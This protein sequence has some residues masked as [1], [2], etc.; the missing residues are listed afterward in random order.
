MFKRSV[1]LLA[2]VVAPLGAQTFKPGRLP[3]TSRDSF[4]IV[5]QGQSIG[6]FVMS[7]AKT[8]ENITLVSDA[9]ISVMGGVT[10]LDSLVFNATTLAPV[11]AT[12]A[13]AMGPM[14]ANGRVTIANGKATG[15]VQQPGPNG[16]QTT[17]VDVAIPAGTILDG[18]DALLIPTIDFSDGLS[19]TFKT[20]DG[21]SGK[22]KDYTLKVVGKEPVTV[23]AGT[24]EAWKTEVTSDEM[25]QIWVSTAEPRK[26]LML[27]LESQQLEMKRTSK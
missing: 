18:A 8:G 24:F 7:H 27:R 4:E 1:L 19:V 21:K 25:A 26:I 17:P 9:R 11:L 20:F 5:Y 23:P 6:T 13:Q 15:T 10:D 16:V 2:T 3:A 22:T 14:T 12:S